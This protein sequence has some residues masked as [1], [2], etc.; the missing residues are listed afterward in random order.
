MDLSDLFAHFISAQ[1]EATTS[2]FGD[3]KDEEHGLGQL[4]VCLF[5]VVMCAVLII[6][7]QHLKRALLKVKGFERRLFTA[8]TQ[9]TLLSLTYILQISLFPACHSS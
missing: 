8:L 7:Q 5:E 6:P 3:V 9:W 2:L 1:D 4:P